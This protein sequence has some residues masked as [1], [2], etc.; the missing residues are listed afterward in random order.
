[1]ANIIRRDPFREL[2]SW[3]RAM[4]RMMEDF[5]GDS[6]LRFM[7]NM[8][9]RMPLDVIENEDEFVVKADIAGI[10]PENIEITYTNNNLTIKGEV[11]DDREENEEEGRYHLRER[12]YGTFCRTISMPGTVDVNNIEAVSE[13]GVL[14]LHLPKKEEVKP[15][16]I[17][18]KV[19][20][21]KN[22][23]EGK[24]KDK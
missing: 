6:E 11:S 15:K 12:R 3:N 1:M 24:S 8:N 13:N 7:D 14:K 20:T 4:E 18:I 23:I 2:L 21:G 19:N 16:R 5:Y 22:V 17:D 10:G 9:L